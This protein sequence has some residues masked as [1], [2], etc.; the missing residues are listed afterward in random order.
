VR[1]GGVAGGSGGVVESDSTTRV[2]GVVR[3]QILVSGVDGMC[4][5]LDATFRWCG[6]V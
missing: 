5:P 3:T 4:V 1:E 2:M 6:C